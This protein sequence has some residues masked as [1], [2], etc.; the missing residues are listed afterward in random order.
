MEWYKSILPTTFSSAA[1]LAAIG[2]IFRNWFVARITESIKHEYSKE[3]ES[4][5]DN[6]RK[7]TDS[8][9]TKLHGE[10]NVEVEKAKLKFSFYSECQFKTYNELWLNLCE[11]KSSMFELWTSASQDNLLNFRDKLVKASDVIERNSLLIEPDHY[12]Q[13]QRI[14]NEFDQFQLGKQTLMELRQEDISGSFV[15]HDIRDWINHNLQTKTNL[16]NCIR[17]MRDCLR[18]Q[19]CGQSGN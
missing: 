19:I 1:L 10:V 16:L 6:L 14:L 3:L 17:E 11:L 2:F 9:L 13:F 8:E 18:N 5:K 4:H 15:N 7:H 12:S